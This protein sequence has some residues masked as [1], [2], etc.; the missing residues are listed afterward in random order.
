[1]SNFCSSCGQG[2]KS[3]NA[4]VCTNCGSAVGTLTKG[5]ESG[6]KGLLY[7]GAVL[8]PIVG[9]IGGFI[10]LFNDKNRGTGLALIVLSFFMWVVWAG[11]FMAAMV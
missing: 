2:I 7:L 10:G 1:M 3:N 11:V 5:W 9:L 6:T 4:V 8:M